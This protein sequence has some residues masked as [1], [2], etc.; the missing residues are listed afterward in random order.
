MALLTRR[1]LL[2]SSGLSVL[3]G[4]ATARVG[5][6]QATDPERSG[7]EM[8]TPE[9]D[10]AI[11]RGLAYLGERQRDDGSLGSGG[12]ARNTAVCGLSGLAWMSG[13]STPLSGPY[14]A[15]LSRCIDFLLANTSDEGFISVT[16]SAS[17]GP[18]YGHGF[19][20]MFLAEVY[21]VTMQADVRQ[22]L[23][24]AVA[25]IVRTQNQDGGWRYQPQPTEAD[26]SVTVCQIM[27]LRAARNAGLH[28]PNESVD[29]CINYVKR[30]QNGDGGFMYM[31]QGGPSAFPRTAAGI[32]ALF[33]AGIYEGPEIERGLHYL[34]DYLP[35]G[36]TASRESHYFYGHYYAV[37]AMWHAGGDYWSKWFPAI[38]DEL[39]LRQQENGS[40]AD[41]IC[42]E[43]G[44][45]MASIILQM[46]NNY[47]PIFQ[48]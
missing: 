13:G 28:V 2:K 27:A 10:Q 18:M 32:V 7:T 19:A 16:G 4:L 8:I 38:R 5:Y 3:A 35:R 21:G 43:Y 45:S 30:S 20:T 29:A 33:S 24:K 1:S 11:S 34:M 6:G 14:A 42:A 15:Q 12:Y 48:R 40:W 47:L 26:I 36:G 39:L 22:K 44:A 31:I 37:Q 17:H 9:T 25:L 23:S 46:P 41:A